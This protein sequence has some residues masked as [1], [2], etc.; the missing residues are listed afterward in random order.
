MLMVLTSF[1]WSNNASKWFWSCAFWFK[2]SMVLANGLD[3]LPFGVMV[4][5]YGHLMLKV[6]S[7]IPLLS[8][9]LSSRGQ[10]NLPHQ[11]SKRKCTKKI[12][13]GLI[14]LFFFHMIEWTFNAK[15]LSFDAKGWFDCM[16][17]KNVEWPT[18]T[19]K[20]DSFNHSKN[21]IKLVFQCYV[22]NLQVANV[23]LIMQRKKVFS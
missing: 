14:F 13:M 16:K 11:F 4:F 12:A 5:V 9:F 22:T 1:F 20:L 10:I 21:K 2:I 7:L 23:H 15:D 19:I 17:K 6:T 18:F 3:P 8:F